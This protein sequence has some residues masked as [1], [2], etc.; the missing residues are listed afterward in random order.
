MDPHHARQLEINLKGNR[1]REGRGVVEN[2]GLCVE[3]EIGQRSVETNGCTFCAHVFAQNM[4][5]E[6]ADSLFLFRVI[7]EN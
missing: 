3:L 1:G 7:F 5:Y 4:V 2:N 6:S